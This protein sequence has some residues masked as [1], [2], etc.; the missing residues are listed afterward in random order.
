MEAEKAH[1]AIEPLD[2]K[3]HSRNVFSCEV[4]SLQRYLR[5]QAS[6]DVKK[7]AA[8]V[9][10]LAEGSKIL[11]YYTLSSYAIDAGELPPDL[12]RRLPGYPILPAILI[13]RLARDQKYHGQGIGE[14]LLLD[15]LRK[16][17][18]STATVGAVAVVV[19]AE[20]E[21]ARKFYVD[22]GLVQF[23]DN[24]NKLFMLMHTVKEIFSA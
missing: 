6:Q 16:C 5:T 3:R 1:R 4:E 23:P 2:K 17:L 22:Y 21:N 8:A 9:F 7:N 15:A 20:N 10:V 18:A 24:P 19:D 13:G 14:L 12:A 11:G